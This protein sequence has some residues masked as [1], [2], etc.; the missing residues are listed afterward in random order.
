MVATTRIL[1]LTVEIICQKQKSD[2]IP[3][4][5]SRSL[6]HG[7]LSEQNI[8]GALCT[9]LGCGCVSIEVWS[10]HY[11]WP[12]KPQAKHI[13]LRHAAESADTSGWRESVE[14]AETFKASSFVLWAETSPLARPPAVYI[15]VSNF[16]SVTLCVWLWARLDDIQWAK[17]SQY[18]GKVSES[19]SSCTALV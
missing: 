6:I 4:T 3:L 14:A 12:C 17:M 2:V 5:A 18:S 7:S 10:V 1:L 11:H 13:L 8:R 19:G 15:E 9:S 16:F